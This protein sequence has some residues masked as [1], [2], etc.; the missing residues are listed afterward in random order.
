MLTLSK[1]NIDRHLDL[2]TEHWR[3][4][5]KRK[6]P[7]ANFFIVDFCFFSCVNEP[8]NFD[9]YLLAAR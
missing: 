1:V 5:S 7:K 9:N 4:H 3:E 6:Q 8:N 2:V